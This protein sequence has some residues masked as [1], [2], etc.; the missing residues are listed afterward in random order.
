MIYIANATKQLFR[1]MHRIP[2]SGK[3]LMVDIPSGRQMPIGE[4]WNPQQ[5][6]AAISHIERFGGRSVN[7]SRINPDDFDGVLYSAGKPVTSDKIAS[8]HDVLVEKQEK[9]SATEATRGALAYDKAN[10]DK[11]GKRLA[12]VSEVEVVQDVPAREKPTGNEVNFKLTVS[13]DGSENAK[14]PV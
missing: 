9:R 7:D 2:E 11:H 5:I 10:R 13:P 4:N 6:E 3:V 12:K 1:F 14:I 8:A